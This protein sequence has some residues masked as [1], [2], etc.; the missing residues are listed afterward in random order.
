MSM[1]FVCYSR[2][3]E[4]FVIQLTQELR[5]K[6]V[7]VWRDQDDIDA[8]ENWDDAIER[9]LKACSHLLFVMSPT[10]VESREVTGEWRY[11]LKQRKKIVPIM[12]KQCEMPRQ[13]YEIHY[14]DFTGDYGSAI[15]ELLDAL[16]GARDPCTGLTEN[17]T[18]KYGVVKGDAKSFSLSA[19]VDKGEYSKTITELAP[20]EFYVFHFK[21]VEVR[22]GGKYA[23]VLE[24]LNRRENRSGWV[25]SFADGRDQMTRAYIVLN[26]K[27][28]DEKT[29]DIDWYKP[30]NWNKVRLYYCRDGSLHLEINGSKISR[31]ITQNSGKISLT[32]RAYAMDIMFDG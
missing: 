5:A 19:P 13:L 14:L 6:G 24:I 18:W 11:A 31:Y 25:F 10:A 15:D 32:T 21:V 1:V 20:G 8:G 22:S 12:Y 28:Q 30:G 7:N 16:R 9:A 26:G 27:Y 23:R 17:T 4:Q 2:D 3:D 29:F